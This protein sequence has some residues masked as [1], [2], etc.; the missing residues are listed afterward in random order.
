VSNADPRWFCHPGLDGRGGEAATAFQSASQATPQAASVSNADP[1]W[2]CHP[3]LDGRGGE[4]ATA[5]Q[6]ASQATP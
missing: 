3:G 4:A 2:F 5:F 1:R 6:S